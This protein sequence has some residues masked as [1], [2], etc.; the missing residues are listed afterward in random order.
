MRTSFTVDYSVWVAAAVV[1]SCATIDSIVSYHIVDRVHSSVVAWAATQGVVA[2]IAAYTVKFRTCANDVVSASSK[3][4]VI[5][6]LS[7]V[8]DVCSCC[9]SDV[10]GTC[11]S[12]NCRVCE[13]ICIRQSGKL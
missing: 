7:C 5:S 8:N 13:W 10:V 2:Y 1:E 3:Y 6:A 4:P 11:C 9:S 12:C